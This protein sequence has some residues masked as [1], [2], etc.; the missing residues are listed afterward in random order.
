MR[1]KFFSL[2]AGG[3]AAGHR[4]GGRQWA[5]RQVAR[6]DTEMTEPLILQTTTAAWARFK[7]S[8]G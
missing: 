2:A 4:A 1:P 5:G 7:I 6:W 3:G 8:T